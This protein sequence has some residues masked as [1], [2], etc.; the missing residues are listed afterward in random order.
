MSAGLSSSC[1]LGAA[2]CEMSIT[3]RSTR[4]LLTGGQISDSGF[5]RISLRRPNLLKANAAWHSSERWKEG[6]IS[7][8]S[9]ENSEQSRLGSNSCDNS[10][11]S[12]LGSN[13]INI[14]DQSRIGSNSSDNSDQS[15]LGSNS[16]SFSSIA[17]Q[18]Q[19][20][21]ALTALAYCTQPQW[22]YSTASVP[23]LQMCDTCTS[24]NSSSSSSGCINERGDSNTCLSSSSTGSINGSDGH[25][26]DLPHWK[27][28][29]FPQI[30]VPA[31]AAVLLIMHA[32]CPETAQA[33]AA[34]D[35]CSHVSTSI[36]QTIVVRSLPSCWS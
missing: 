3:S 4:L 14:S 24:T 28:G 17:Y 33:A 20:C 25:L 11:Q 8:C 2:V 7:C 9:G 23:G 10:D 30:S 13:R 18:W 35:Q 15:R 31:V 36:L 16:S 5:S 1:D 19:M 22:Q 12:R 6:D 34:C 26:V 21:M 29:A 32:F 27:L